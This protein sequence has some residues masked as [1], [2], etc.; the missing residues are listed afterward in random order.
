MDEELH[1]I[2]RRAKRGDKE[3]YAQLVKDFKDPVYRYALGML[4]D[5]MDAEDIA[6][7]AFVK[8][9]YSLPGLESEFAFSSWLFQIVSNLSKNRLKKRMRE[10]NYYEEAEESTMAEPSDPSE[11]LSIEQSLA[12]LS[13]EHRE[14]ILLHDVQGYRYEEIAQVTNVPLGTVKSRLFAARTALRNDLRKGEL[15]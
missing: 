2:I 7:E 14:V 5:R 3:A 13:P 9:Y 15:S 8:A 10:R 4:N 6:Q 11:K 12:R 1:R